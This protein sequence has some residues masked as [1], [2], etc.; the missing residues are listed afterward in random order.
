MAPGIVG[1]SAASSPTGVAV[2]GLAAGL[3]GC[4]CALRVTVRGLNE[5][6]CVCLVVMRPSVT[7]PGHTTGHVTALPSLWTVH[8]LESG[9]GGLGG[10]A[11]I[12]W[13]FQPRGIA[14]TQGRVWILLLW[15]EGSPLL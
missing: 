3:V 14:A 9:V 1:D 15:F 13:R 4:A 6:A 11:G 10:G 5:C 2:A 8:G 7:G 12:A